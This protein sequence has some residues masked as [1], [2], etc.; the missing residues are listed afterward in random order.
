MTFIGNNSTTYTA[1]DVDDVRPEA[2]IKS[3]DVA[4][5][6]ANNQAVITQYI[7]GKQLNGSS[8]Y[9]GTDHDHDVT[10]GGFPLAQTWGM[11]A[12]LDD[13]QFVSFGGAY[14]GNGYSSAP[15][16]RPLT[17][18]VYTNST[19]L[20]HIVHLVAK[21]LDP[22][23]PSI[24][25]NSAALNTTIS[26]ADDVQSELVRAFIDDDGWSHYF[27]DIAITT[28]SAITVSLQLIHPYNDA[29]F[30]YA[31]AAH[32][33]MFEVLHGDVNKA[34][35]IY[36]S[37]PVVSPAEVH[38]LTADTRRGASFSPVP[39]GLVDNNLPLSD[40][41]VTKLAANNGHVFEQVTGQPAPGHATIAAT[42]HDHD[43]V[44]S[45]YITMVLAGGP[46]GYGHL[47]NA[48]GSAYQL[49]T[50]IAHAGVAPTISR[51][52]GDGTGWYDAAIAPVW[53]PNASSG[54][55]R[56]LYAFLTMLDDDANG[57]KFRM[58]VD[59][60]PTFASPSTSAA[61][62][63]AAVAGVLT[64]YRSLSI[65]TDQM[66]F[67]KLQF[68]SREVSAKTTGMVSALAWAIE[69]L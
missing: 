34:P 32:V 25:V 53:L 40:Y 9:G 24:I 50:S 30:Y 27:A 62:S 48:G 68:A 35:D 46:L 31:P 51:G 28:S 16:K 26:T 37:S 47:G 10:D 12:T 3:D 6:L 45:D 43:A 69:A 33:K 56:T 66:V 20:S 57:V 58:L 15:T 63:P 22:Y 29:S 36:G 7:S 55:S 39:E 41:L 18:V 1:L 8:T 60:D 13:Q 23:Q 65:T 17:I 14:N 5:S 21:D 49:E 61:V 52:D 67:V 42:A 11:G 38:G 64:T 59:T 2:D 54:T 19:R 44:N 4:D